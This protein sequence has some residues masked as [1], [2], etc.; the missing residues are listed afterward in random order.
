MKA[1]ASL[2]EEHNRW[3]RIH[4][5][6]SYGRWAVGS[7]RTTTASNKN[8][9]KLSSGVRSST[10][11]DDVSAGGEVPP[12]RR[13]QRQQSFENEVGAVEDTGVLGIEMDLQVGQMT[14]RSKHLSALIPDIANHPDVN[15]LFGDATIQASLIESA[16]HRFRYRLVGL[17]HEIDYWPTV[18]YV[19]P[20]LADEY[21]REY[22]PAELF[23]SEKWIT[24]VSRNSSVLYVKSFMQY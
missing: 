6:R 19:C 9:L 23:D 20:P 24:S 8:L 3:S 11:S 1:S 7:T 15:M 14:L 2:L 21:D 13:L 17:N 22:D 4:G 10:S 18:H 5:D 12:P 16:E